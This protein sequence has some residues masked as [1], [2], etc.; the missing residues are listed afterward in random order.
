MI[1][2]IEFTD[3]SK[4]FWTPNQ[5]DF[6]VW[7]EF[8]LEELRCAKPTTVSILLVNLEEAFRLN[9]HHRNKDYAANVLSFPANLPDQATSVL[10]SKPIGD[11]VICP[12]I[13]QREADEQKKPINAHWAHLLIHSALHLKGFH[14]ETKKEAERMEKQEIKVLKKLGFPNP[15][16][17]M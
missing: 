2:T 1:V 16:L 6:Q 14:H 4:S 11:I 5:N 10:Y 9:L 15:Y 12:E 17:I 7:I 13:L 3:E 8:V